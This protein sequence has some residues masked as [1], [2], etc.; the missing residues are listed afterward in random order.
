MARKV[1]V[2]LYITGDTTDK[3]NFLT[4]FDTAL[5]VLGWDVS[6]SPYTYLKEFSLSTTDPTIRT[7]ISDK[8][9]LYYINGLVIN[10]T[11]NDNV[12]HFE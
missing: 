7:E 9:A 10:A 12:L 2:S 11:I 4:D 8:I 3:T 1:E 6:G 5:S